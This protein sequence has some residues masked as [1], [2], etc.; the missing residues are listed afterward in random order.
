[1]FICPVS[2]VTAFRHH[3][4]S[5]SYGNFNIY[6]EPIKVNGEEIHY[7]MATQAYTI[8]F[9]L[10]ESPVLSMPIGISSES[11]PISI[12]VIG[13]RYEDFRLLEIGRAICTLTDK[14]VYPLQP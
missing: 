5:K 12:Q 6:N 11:L 10:T 8:P 1:V 3:A 2:A 14:I 7:Y 13:K 9:S 4:P